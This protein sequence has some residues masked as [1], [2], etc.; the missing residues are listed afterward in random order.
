LRALW[1]AWNGVDGGGDIR[2]IWESFLL[3]HEAL[4][5]HAMTWN[6]ELVGIGNLAVKLIDFIENRI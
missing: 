3:Q 5:G 4:A 6:D 1:H 2:R